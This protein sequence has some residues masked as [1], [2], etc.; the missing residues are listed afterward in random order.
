[1][2]VVC[3]LNIT[4]VKGTQ[5]REVD[6][7]RLDHNGVRENRRFYL[8]NDQDEMVNSLRMGGLHTALCSYSDADRRLRLELPDGQAID[9]PI[10]LGPEVS[11]E[12]Y[13]QPRT[14]R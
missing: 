12:F 2:A 1:M 5:L 11:T 14:A 10:E 4:P 3:R 8:I 7:V 13:G 6:E 9:E